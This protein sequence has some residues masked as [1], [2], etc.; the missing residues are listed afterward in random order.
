MVTGQKVRGFLFY[1]SVGVFCIGLP[2]ILSFALS[3]KFDPHT[4]I[5]RKAGLI[6][7][8]TQPAGA[9]IYLNE[10]LQEDKTPATINELLPGDYEV[11]F[12][13]QQYYSWVGKISVEAG[14]V[15]RL[16]KVILFPLRPDIVQ[17]SRYPF[18]T[19][20]L[21]KDGG[22]IY[23]LDA[24]D[25]H[26][27]K[28]DLNGA[29]TENIAD[30]LEIKPYPRKWVVSEDGLRLL[31]FNP[32]QLVVLSLKDG[33]R[34]PS[35]LQS[36]FIDDYSN[37]LILDAFWYSDNYHIVVVTNKNIEVL[38]GKYG[39]QPVNLISLN[40]SNTTAAYDIQTDTIYFIDSQVAEDGHSYD[41]LY[42]LQLRNKVSPFQGLMNLSPALEKT[43]AQEEK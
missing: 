10:K 41:N 43:N 11:S 28:S 34:N 37:R 19:F 4:F 14:K 5:F 35:A 42:K 30:F 36:P 2:W 31:Y 40:K 12:Q 24:Q 32:H 21:D 29:H 22:F 20:W 23:Y 39:S 3:Y 6:V 7:C 33:E 27:Y 38:E 16:E 18:S 17:L 13:L 25:K 9:S 1:L 8:K 15:A 26:I